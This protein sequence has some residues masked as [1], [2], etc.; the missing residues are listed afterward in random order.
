MAAGDGERAENQDMARSAN[1]RLQDVAGRTA[2]DG[3]VIPFLCECAADGCFGRV[4]I[5]ID[6]YFIA[7]LDSDHYVI[8]SG[9]PRID[10]E[11]VVDDH[12]EYEVVTKAAAAA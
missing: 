2:A 4:E 1:E 8:V 7:H 3:V 6:D 11:V 12:G 5:T 9:H 10:G